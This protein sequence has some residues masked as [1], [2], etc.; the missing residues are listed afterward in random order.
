MELRKIVGEDKTFSANSLDWFT[1]VCC[2][3]LLLSHQCRNFNF[4]L[5]SSALSSTFI[6]HCAD[7]LYLIDN[8]LPSF[9]SLDT[10]YHHHHHTRL[11]F[12][13][14]H[15]SLN[16]AK[17]MLLVHKYCIDTH[18]NRRVLKNIKSAIKVIFLFLYNRFSRTRTM[19]FSSFFS[20]FWIDQEEHALSISSTSRS[21]SSFP[22]YFIFKCFLWSHVT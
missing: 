5:L 8:I 17:K 14:D 7:W 20:L 4:S 11:Y 12:F 16:I 9:P 19:K 3:Y 6:F 18:T 10:Y 22:T 15:H 21:L 2:R 13:L 1:N